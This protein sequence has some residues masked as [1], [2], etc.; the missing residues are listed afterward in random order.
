MSAAPPR[1]TSI[2]LGRGRHAWRSLYEQI[3]SFASGISLRRGP[4]N[5]P[6]L[7]SSSP[8]S[9]ACSPPPRPSKFSLWSAPRAPRAYNNNVRRSFASGGLLLVGF[10]PTSP[11]TTTVVATCADSAIAGTTAQSANISKLARQAWQ[12]NVH[13]ARTVR[14]RARTFRNPRRTKSSKTSDEA[15]KLASASKKKADSSQLSR[16]PTSAP[17]SETPKPKPGEEHPEPAP[18]SKYF[19]LPSIP[20]LPHLPHLPH[21]PTKEEFL[22]AANGFWQRLRV[23]FKWFSIR[24]MRPWNADE[25]GAFVS[26]FLFGHLVWVLVGTTTFFSLIILCINTVFAQGKF[27]PRICV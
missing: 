1:A 25:W 12:R 13:T 22:A 8:F 15:G 7:N 9:T 5:R 19:H 2:A 17:P 3:N 16:D 14:G 11:A 26:W 20:H 18:V 10:T 4:V 21:R 6:G 27:R 23:R 24:S